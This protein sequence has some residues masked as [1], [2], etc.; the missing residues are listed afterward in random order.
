MNISPKNLAAV[1]LQGWSDN[2]LH[3]YSGAYRD[4]VRYGGILGKH[5]YRWNSGDISSFL[6]NGSNNLPNSIKKFSA[7]LTL[8]FGCCDRASPAS[9]P[10]VS[11]VKVGISKKAPRPLW[12]PEN[13]LTFV[14]ALATP[15]IIF[16]DW[17]IMALQLLC[18]L[19]MRRFNDFQNIKVGDIRVLA[20]G[21]LRLFKKIGKTFQLGQGSF[22]HLLNKPLGGFSVKGVMDQYVNKLG[23]KSDDYLFP[24]F[25]SPALVS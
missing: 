2:I 19:S 15:D 8:F 21:D 16:L 24:R 20:N 1:Y 11:N 17:R 14:S 3:A 10:L 9:G 7:V 4:I 12:S 25:Q 18:Y 13:L 5:W 22:I 23:L 6:I